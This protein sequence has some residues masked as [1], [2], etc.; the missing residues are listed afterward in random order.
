MMTQ[1]FVR[2]NLPYLRIVPEEDYHRA[3]R[4]GEF[5]GSHQLADFRTCPRLYHKKM[6]GEI[7]RTDSSAFQFGRA[8]HKL[9]L[10]GQPAFNEDF[11]VS[12]GPVNPRT[13]E[14]FGRLTK[15]Y[16][17][18]AAA[19]TADV[20]SPEDYETM[21]KIVGAMKEHREIRRLLT[22]GFPEGTIR[23]K[24]CG[25]DLQAR[26]D[27]FCPYLEKGV[28]A[29]VDLKTCENLDNFEHDA[30]RYGYPQQL[31][32][33]RHALFCA[34]EDFDEGEGRPRTELYIIAVEKREPFR[35]GVWK[36]T[37]DLVAE[38][39]GVNLR[40]MTRL[41]KCRETDEWPTDYE[42]MRILDIG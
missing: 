24:S 38:A 18:W 14:P 26:L 22:D 21:R 35:V 41:R 5:V 36:L 16:K 28:Q 39:D 30:R 32:F 42:E 15:A 8:L 13:G 6:T 19:Q 33:Y 37:D 29:I 27:W 20:V 10:E 2:E 25:L 31:A 17:E 9:A 11:V 3:A 34:Q 4:E 23:V 7:E 40:A 12:A 1:Q